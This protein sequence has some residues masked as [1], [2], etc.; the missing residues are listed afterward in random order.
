MPETDLIEIRVHGRGGQGGVT[1]AKILAAIHAHLGRSVQAFGDYGGERSGAP[2]RAYLRASRAPITS[3]NKVYAPDHLIVLDPS[4]L[5]AGTLSGLKGGGTLLLNTS[6]PID[7]FN[8]RFDAFRL[9]VI[10]ATAIARARGI[11]SRAV[12][13]VNTTIAGAFARIFDLPFA[14]LEHAYQHLG[15][16]RDLPAAREAF[17]RVQVRETAEAM[18]P[19]ARLGL[20]PLPDVMPLVEH[21]ESPAVTL[22]TGSWRTQTPRYAD[23]LAPCSA[24]CPA[25]NDVVGFVQALDKHGVEA[26]AEILAKTTPLPSVCGRVC[27]AP[28]MD[29]CNRR[30][31]DG[32]VDIRALERWI[33]DHTEPA[34]PSTALGMSEQGT[35][36]VSPEPARPSTALGMSE[37]GTKAIS[38][39]DAHAEAAH[40]E[41][42]HPERSRGTSGPGASKSFAI[43][44]GG[45]AG[46]S[47]AHA[48]AT[49]GHRATIL[50]ADRELGGVL[51][52]GIPVYRL[53]REALDR[54]IGRLL[55]RGVEA[56]LGERISR[57]R[58]ADLA[59]DFDGVILATG[60]E[61]QR[62]LDVPGAKLSGITQ[63]LT[64]LR[65]LAMGEK[66]ALDGDVVVLG[67]GNTAIDCARSA[68]RAGAARVTIAYRRGR[69][70]MPAIKEEITEA[71]NEGVELA[72]LRAP[73]GFSGNGRVR[74]VRLAE[75]ELGEP[76]QSGRRSPK[77]TERVDELACDVVLLALGQ[78][79]DLSVL[80]ERW[81]LRDGRCFD[82]EHATRVFAAGDVSTGEGTVTHAIGDGR[83]AAFRAMAACGLEVEIP[84]RLDVANAVPASA[85]RFGHYPGSSPAAHE[86][87][88]PSSLAGDFAEVD[89]GLASPAEASR[90]FSCGTCTECDTC[91][92]YCPEGII[93]RRPGGYDIDL[94]QCKGC[95]I[96]VAE[97]PRKAMEMVMT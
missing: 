95:G 90:C 26:A 4:L 56:R 78:S 74:A 72:L 37:Q 8:G 82:G 83:R 18:A 29:G 81:T 31:L 17:E 24:S 44:G 16:A 66:I 94:E 65:Q 38:P 61:R 27:P 45:P 63:G 97:C 50:E 89:G 5:D 21:T 47:A 54:D 77:V 49:L 6:E 2:I 34:R 75:V 67:G 84:P 93:D 1:A 57:E 62:G 88:V 42:A 30:E 46:L 9:A 70:E 85:V 28:C 60:L 35:N 3:R 32:A 40:A 52:S 76:D 22:K 12:V 14:A 41:A 55:A 64:F 15:L 59:R 69:D 86:H 19:G 51:R 20:P 36:A 23:G 43:V 68:L 80:P 11:G 53:A 58:V 87:R 13:I 33:G 48:L 10:D 73:V 79:A 39:D 7:A 96:C 92:V 25:G 91:L 71:D